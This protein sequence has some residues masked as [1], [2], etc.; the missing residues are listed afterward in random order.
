V[1]GYNL[2]GGYPDLMPQHHLTT[3]AI[4]CVG[5]IQSSLRFRRW[6]G[7]EEHYWDEAYLQV[8]TD[9]E[10]WTTLWTNPN[11]VLDDQQWVQQYFDVHALV[12]GQPA[13]YFRWTMGP[14]DW[15][16]NYCGWNIDDVELWGVRDTPTN[17]GDV[18]CDGAVTFLDINP[19]VLLLADPGGY[20]AQFPNCPVLNGDC[21][22][23][24]RV[25]FSDINPFVA[26][27]SR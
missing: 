15:S 2:A 10:N 19:F 8:S 14:S 17:P 25:D 22:G 4:N 12:D 11:V 20:A 3:P 5:I 9:R 24:G 1:Y 7:V 18:N 27:L 21:N 23:D 13:V 16:I 6:L 26:L